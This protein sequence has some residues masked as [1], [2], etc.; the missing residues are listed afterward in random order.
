MLY[1]MFKMHMIEERT[2][3]YM[4]CDANLM[5]MILCD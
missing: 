2:C 3:E 5:D 4:N 1:V